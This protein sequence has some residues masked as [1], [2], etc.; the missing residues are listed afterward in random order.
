VVGGVWFAVDDGRSR[1]V[2][3]GDV[4]PDSSVF[5]MDAIPECDLLILDASYGADPVAGATRAKAIAAWIDEH[6]AGCLLPTPLS[7]RSLELM[8]GLSGPFA[9]HTAMRPSLQAQ[10][11]ASR[12]LLPGMSE[13]LRRRLENAR[14]WTDGDPLPSCPLLTDDGMGEAGPSSHLLPQADAASFPILLTGH[15]P[16]GSP[17][18]V[19]HRK[20][21]ASWIRMPTHPTLSGNVGIWEKAGRPAAIGH[22]CAPPALAELAAHIPTL[23]VE[24]HTGQTLTVPMEKAS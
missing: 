3:S 7:G 12:A 14:D 1:V 5:V 15:L 22:S 8:A 9:I 2:Y 24:C 11:D 23:A 6:A 21:R 16:V 17:A 13:L 4:V 20:G 10:I 18:D 19:I